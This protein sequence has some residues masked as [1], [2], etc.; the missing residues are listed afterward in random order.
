MPISLEDFADTAAIKH[1]DDFF[2]AH[3]NAADMT[4]VHFRVEPNILEIFLRLFVKIHRPA[5]ASIDDQFV[6]RFIP[7]SLA[8]F[9]VHFLSGWG[10][11]A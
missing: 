11:H 7:I 3:D 5:R 4:S 8:R 2:A 1:R 6:A 9:H 10:Q